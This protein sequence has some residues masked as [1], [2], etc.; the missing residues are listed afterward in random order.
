MLP[1]N[2]DD[3]SVVRESDRKVRLHQTTY[4]IN[5]G[6]YFDTDTRFTHEVYVGGAVRTTRLTKYAVDVDLSQAQDTY[7]K[8]PNPSGGYNE[9]TRYG[10][11][12]TI[13]YILGFGL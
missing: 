3:Q 6:Y 8:E 4:S 1:R 13:G 9:V 7:Y 11:I 10:F 2:L 12:F 5:T